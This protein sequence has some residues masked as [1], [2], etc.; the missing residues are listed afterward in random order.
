LSVDDSLISYQSNG[1]FPNHGGSGR[2]ILEGAK[3]A[4]FPMEPPI[5]FQPAIDLKPAEV[6]GLHISVNLLFYP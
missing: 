1:P 3:S 6:L 5:H 2:Q 4:D